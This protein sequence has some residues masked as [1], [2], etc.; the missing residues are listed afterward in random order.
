MERLKWLEVFTALRLNDVAA[1]LQDRSYSE[2]ASIG[3]DVLEC[4]RHALLA[5]FIQREQINEVSLD[6]FGEEIRTSYVRYTQFQFSLASE[7]RRLLLCLNS[8]PRSLKPFVTEFG[9]ALDGDFAIGE[10]TIDVASFVEAAGEALAPAKLK[11]VQAAY[12]DVPLTENSN[13]RVQVASSRNAIADFVSRLE[14]GRLDKATV[15]VT[16]PTSGQV[17]FEIGRRASIRYAEHEWDD[18]TLFRQLIS[19]NLFNS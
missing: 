1:R 6:P 19:A 15:Q 8:P 4:S 11:V 14:T 2:D 7:Q 17:E 18:T 16:T 10:L 12:V 3:F 13:C 5:R 9:R